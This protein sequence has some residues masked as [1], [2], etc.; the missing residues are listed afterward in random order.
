MHLASALATSPT[1]QRHC[2]E[3]TVL[4]SI[5]SR[6]YPRFVQEVERSGGHLPQFVR[7]EFDEYLKCGLLEHGFLRVK[8]D[9]CRHEHL[10]A[11]SCKRRGFCPSCGARRMVESA[12]HLVD[13]VFPEVPIRQFVLTFPF[14][15]RF[16]LAAEPQ[17]LT[18]VLAVV[19][20]GIS[21]FLVRQAGFTLAS[22]AKTG[23]VTLIQRFGS[24]LNLNPHHHMLFLDGAY[25]FG[26]NKARFH[27]AR[28]A[29]NDDPG[30]SPGQVLARL[31]DALAR[32]IAR[33]LERRGLLIADAGNPNFELELGSSLDQIQAASIHYRIAVGP[34]AGRRALTLYSVPPLEEEPGIP[35]LARLYGFSLHAGTV[36]EA[37]QRSKLERLCRYITR[38]PVATKRLSIDDRGRVVYR[39]KRPFRDGSTHVVLEPLDFIAR[40][41]ALVPRPRL[42]LTRWHGV[43]APNFKHRRRIVP[44]RVRGKVDSDKPLAPMNWA[45]RLKRVFQIDI[46]SCPE[47]GGC[48]RVIA[49]IEDPQLIAHILAHV[50]SRE[51]ATAKAMT[52]G[53]PDEVVVV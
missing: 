27:R 40:L 19:Q 53:P 11:F 10:V 48:V 12:A 16:L 50:R 47:C 4:Y 49:C 30:S 37:H 7:Q 23:A 31:L 6:H 17:A 15:L 52:R 41:A 3:R 21:S 34:H 43:F 32:R 14:P 45:Q 8:C 22:G 39:Y 28:R 24:A 2:P 20:R 29:T 9:G 18:K 1:Y 44:R 42:N 5:I 26:G 25:R 36:C 33:L 13:H 38:P 46:E 51:A 35:P